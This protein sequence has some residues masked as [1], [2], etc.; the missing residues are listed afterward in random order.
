[1]MFKVIPKLLQALSQ[2]GKIPGRASDQDLYLFSLFTLWILMNPKYLY[3]LKFNKLFE[4]RASCMNTCNYGTI[5]K[6]CI[7]KIPPQ[8][9]STKC[10]LNENEKEKR[11]INK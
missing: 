6:S 8:G 4:D 2:K 5:M 1:M 3:R 10:Q 7:P 9:T 11:I